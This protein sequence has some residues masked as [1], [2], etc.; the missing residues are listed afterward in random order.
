MEHVTLLGAEDVRNAGNAMRV[1]ASEMIRAASEMQD[2]VSR[3]ERALHEHAERIETSLRD[4]TDRIEAEKDCK[5][6]ICREDGR[7]FDDAVRLRQHMT[8]AHKERK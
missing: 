8:D 6:F 7:E 4:H 5:Y 3:L 1:A 2:A